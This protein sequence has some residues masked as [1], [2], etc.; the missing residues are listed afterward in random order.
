MA[1]GAKKDTAEQMKLFAYA[2]FTNGGNG[3][4][5]AIEAGYSAK[6][7]AQIGSRLLTYAK[8]QEILSSLHD[9]LKEKAI[10]TK[11]RIAEELAKI[12]LFDI[13]TCYAESG[14]LL[15]IKD[16]PGD[17]AAVINGIK[18]MEEFAGFG[19]AREK[20][21]ETVEVK[22]N[23]KIAA[24]SELIKLYGYAAPQKIAPT[25]PDGKALP[26]GPFQVQIIPPVE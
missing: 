8:V 7:A 26:Q 19:E 10:V 5:A 25:D 20:I 16:L 13:R 3:T 4:Q 1:K 23:S 15:P 2:Y 21:G 22:L 24:L 11:E 12:G 18:V 6:A 14:A 17:A 9:K